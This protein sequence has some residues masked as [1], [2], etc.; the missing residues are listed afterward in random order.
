MD[1]TGVR[2]LLEAD[3]AAR[4]HGVEIKV[5]ADR[6]VRRVLEVTGLWDRFGTGHPS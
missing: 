4:V 1:S 3:S 2:A 6:V 5:L